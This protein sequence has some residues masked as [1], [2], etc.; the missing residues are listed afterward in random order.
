MYFLFETKP[1]NNNKIKQKNVRRHF[2][3]PKTYANSKLFSDLHGLAWL[4]LAIYT[5]NPR[6]ESALFCSEKQ[7]PAIILKNQKGLQHSTA[8]K[9]KCAKDKVRKYRYFKK[10]KS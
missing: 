3:V 8:K 2:L 5:F 7:K 10:S 4:K 6:N 1:R 9:S